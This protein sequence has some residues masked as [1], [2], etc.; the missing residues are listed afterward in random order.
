MSG[1]IDEWVGTEIERSFVGE[2]PLRDPREYAARG[3]RAQ[4]RRRAAVGTLGAAGLVVAT[5]LVLG[6]SHAGDGP[7]RGIEPARPGDV[8]PVRVTA[9][10]LVDPLQAEKCAAGRVGGC[11]DDIGTDD[12]HLDR[13]GRLLRGYSYDVVTGA[14]YDVLPGT[15]D[16]SAAV[17]LTVRGQTVWA[18]LSVEAGGRSS[19][20]KYEAPD[21]T[22]TF[23]QWVADSVASGAWF[24]YRPDPDGPGEG[25]TP[26]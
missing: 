5:V 3:H 13:S 24:S 9:P 20:L 21:P 25:S 11:G 4:R 8:V 17:E 23:D 19:A 26:R 7:S 12:I 10:I 6:G 2:P 22:R 15:W 1:S 18:L 16:A 14:Y